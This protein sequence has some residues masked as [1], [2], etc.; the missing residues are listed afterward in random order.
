VF[1][2]IPSFGTWVFG[3]GRVPRQYSFF[4]A[5]LFF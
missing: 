1:C 5:P 3:N 2:G 4:F